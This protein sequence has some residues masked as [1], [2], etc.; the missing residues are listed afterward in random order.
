MI[1]FGGAELAA[2]AA[3]RADARRQ[4]STDAEDHDY[5]RQEYFICME[6]AQR[7]FRYHVPEGQSLDIG[8]PLALIHSIAMVDAGAA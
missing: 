6:R 1:Q 8:T 4:V 2:L 3:L 5:W 7:L